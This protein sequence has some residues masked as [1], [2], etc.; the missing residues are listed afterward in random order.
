MWIE[1]SKPVTLSSRLT[2]PQYSLVEWKVLS[3][4]EE[5]VTGIVKGL[6]LFLFI[7]LEVWFELSTKPRLNWCWSIDVFSSSLIRVMNYLLSG[8]YS[9]LAVSFRLKRH[10]GFYVIQD[11]IPTLLIVMLSW[12]GFWIDDR[13][14]PARVSLGITTVLS[15]TTLFFGIQATLP[16]VG[17]IK[18]IDYYLLGSFFFVFGALIEFAIICTVQVKSDRD[19]KCSSSKMDCTGD[20]STLHARW[21]NITSVGETP[22]QLRN[23][24]E[25]IVYVEFPLLISLAIWKRCCFSSYK[26][27][28]E[29]K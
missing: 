22:E 27:V 6:V 2:I 9:V 3:R 23:E 28:R 14:V 4:N 10:L 19:T 11:F 7:I 8:N 29:E 13:S 25:V 21:S 24:S 5:Y 16:K 20:S 12:V 26:L 1:G 18:A 15:I 17:Y